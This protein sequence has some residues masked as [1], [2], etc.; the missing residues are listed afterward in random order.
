MTGKKARR[1]SDHRKRDLQGKTDRAI[2]S[3]SKS[4]RSKSRRSP[5]ARSGEQSNPAVPS[6]AAVLTNVDGL[7]AQPNLGRSSF[8][9]DFRAC[10]SLLER[11]LPPTIVN[12]STELGITRQ[13]TWALQRRH[14]ELLTWI[15]ENFIGR[16]KEYF[17]PV[18]YRLAMLA[19]QG[20]PVHADLYLKSLT[21]G[22]SGTDLPPAGGSVVNQNNGPTINLLVPLPSLPGSVGHAAPAAASL[23]EGLSPLADIPVVAV[24]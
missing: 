9:R 21:M 19:M 15:N 16:N 14:P 11:G 24:R 13:A 22:F 20:S 3:R 6:T 18:Q 7:P 8:W 12:I 1:P 10:V 5:V 2:P 17:G 4:R 23:P